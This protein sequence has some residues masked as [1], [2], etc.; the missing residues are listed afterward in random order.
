VTAPT[1]SIVLPVLLAAVMH[2]GWNAVVKSGQDRVL[3]MAV[4]AGLGAVGAGAAVLFV[5][6]PGP[7]SWKF[8]LL[9]C[10][11]HVGYFIF[12]LK[13]YRVGDLSH[14]YPVARGTAPLLVALGAMAFAGE[15]VGP[16]ELGATLLIAVAIGSFAFE[17][18][19]RGARDARPFLLAL[20]TS[21]I[22]AT[23]TVVDGLGVRSSGAPLSYILWL[24]F[25]DG[26]PL[27]LYALATRGARIGPYLAAHWPLSL[28]GGVM[29]G[30]AYGL[31]IWALSLGAMAYVSALRET[32]V[33]FAA[34][35]G[36]R[37]LGEPFGGRRILAATA[38]AAGILL[39]SLP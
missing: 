35:I 38:V 34:V 27:T 28:A 11:I 13:A 4:I 15:R 20:G 25:L 19:S 16:R 33:I 22:I 31:V 18:T 6:L 29:C 7:A 39:M 1:L 24:L 14:V 21:V 37:L 32:S 9:S 30:A 17:R 10:L 26:L 36:S 8:L 5:P 12:L 3:T 2:A 23:Y